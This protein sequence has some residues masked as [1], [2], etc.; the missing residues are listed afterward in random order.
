MAHFDA[1]LCRMH[2]GEL[3]PFDTA[4]VDASDKDEATAMARKWAGTVEAHE[5][6][7]LQIRLD[8]KSIAVFEPGKF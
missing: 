7:W 2:R 1:Y 8:G 5:D 3:V 6:A 4:T